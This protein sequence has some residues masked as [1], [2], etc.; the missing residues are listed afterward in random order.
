MDVSPDYRNS[1]S[2]ALAET[3][4]EAS[5][6]QQAPTT[7][8][9]TGGPVQPFETAEQTFSHPDGLVQSE[10]TPRD[11]QSGRLIPSILS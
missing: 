10:A 8:A 3:T 6:I 1:L 5:G 2:D 4:S 11:D 7:N 9:F